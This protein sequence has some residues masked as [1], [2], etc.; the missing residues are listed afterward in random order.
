MYQVTIPRNIKNIEPNEVEV[1]DRRK[2]YNFQ[3]LINVY[4]NVRHDLVLFL[5][6]RGTV[7]SANLPFQKD[8]AME[9][10]QMYRL[11]QNFIESFIEIIAKN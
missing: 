7:R 11:T 4:A 3:L 5:G 8:I 6:L 10:A 9:F 2:C 1:V